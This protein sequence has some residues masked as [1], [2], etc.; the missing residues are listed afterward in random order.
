MPS[1]KPRELLRALERAGFFVDR[2]KGSHLTLRHV[3][4]PTRRVTIAMHPVE[5][6]RNAVQQI[7]KQAGLTPEEFLRLL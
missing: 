5:L 2:Q 7:L 3:T 4:D 1:L 6:H